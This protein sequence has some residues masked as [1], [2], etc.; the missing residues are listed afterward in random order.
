MDLLHENSGKPSALSTIST[1]RC[2]LDIGSSFSFTQQGVWLMG[3]YS[4][5]SN[6]SGESAPDFHRLAL[7]FANC[8][9]TAL[10][11]SSISHTRHFKIKRKFL[12]PG[13]FLIIFNRL[14]ML[15]N[16]ISKNSGHHFEENT[17][18]NFSL[19]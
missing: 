15:K 16:K 18:T 3:D 10:K 5:S 6:H 17:I 11:T 12:T 13:L 19:S 1:D 4:K 14:S 9:Q 7:F 2:S 8:I